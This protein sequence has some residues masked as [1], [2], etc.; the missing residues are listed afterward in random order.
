M[1]N[2]TTAPT[3]NQLMFPHR[4]KS[5][6]KVAEQSIKPHSGSM[7]SES[8]QKMLNDKIIDAVDEVL[9]KN[10]AAAIRTLDSKDYTPE[11][12]SN[13]ILSYVQ[14]AISRADT[15]NSNGSEILAQARQGIK[16]GFQ[17]A[18]NILASLNALSG[19]IAENVQKTFDLVQNGL[20]ETGSPSITQRQTS[21][22][23]NQSQS[24]SLDITTGDGDVVTLNLQKSQSSSAY[25]AQLQSTRSNTT[26]SEFNFSSNSNV[27]FSVQGTLD[28]EELVA[29]K[30]LLNN[31]KN[32]A[33]QFFKGDAGAAFEAGL[34]LGFNSSQLTGFS[35][36]LDQSSQIETQAYREVSGFTEYVD[37]SRP[38][39][40]LANLLTP[41]H[42]IAKSLESTLFNAA[43]STSFKESDVEN[44]FSYFSQT[45]DA[46]RAMINQL[47]SLSG[48]PFEN[49][50]HDIISE[51][52]S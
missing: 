19:K 15:R 12:V 13:R 37:H 5:D 25:Q 43:S 8:S 16:R 10:K 41:I 24:F 6:N 4:D 45:D 1:I 36:S 34:G 29:I 30:E 2:Q 3:M 28:E 26:I 7:S 11:A 50:A 31:S 35:L 17:D 20:D 14:A 32:I 23:S 38:P 48:K 42:D 46:H 27:E 33:D 22:S 9:Q 52:T 40:E 47:E 44:L 39:A 49:M 51:I 18:E 21:Y